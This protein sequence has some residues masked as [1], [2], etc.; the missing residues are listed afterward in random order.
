MKSR[1]ERKAELMRAA[2][3][4]IEA[5]LEWTEK[6]ATP[7]LEQ[8]E[9]VVLRL[10]QRIGVQMAQTVVEGTEAV[11]PVPEPSCPECGQRMP[12]KGQKTKGISSWVG[13]LELKRGYFY[14]DHCQSGLFPPGST[15]R[16]GGKELVSEPSERG[17]L[18]ERDD[19]EL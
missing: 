5:L 19:E 17:S 3:V 8:I 9:E 12:Y 2:E 18:A 6:T 16:A 10:R 14:C 4:E 1:A 13:E 11:R 7:N 15:T